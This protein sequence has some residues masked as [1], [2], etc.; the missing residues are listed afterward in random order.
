[1]R[2]I[3]AFLGFASLGLTTT[4]GFAQTIVR[5]YPGQTLSQLTGEAIAFAGDVDGDGVGDHLVGLRIGAGSGPFPGGMNV[6]S[7]ATGQ[8][9][10]QHVGASFNA[11][12]GSAMGALGDIDQDGFADYAMGSR[13]EGGTGSVTAFSGQTGSQLWKVFGDQPNQSYGQ[14]IEPMADLNGDGFQDLLTAGWDQRVWV[15]SGLDGTRLYDLADTNF[16]FGRT[17]LD[18]GD[19]NGDGVHDFYVAAH[20][21]QLNGISTTG[22]VRIFNGATGQVLL[23]EL[24]GTV[25]NG[26]FGGALALVGDRTG[27]GISEVAVGSVF[28]VPRGAVRIINP[29]NRAVLNT[30]R[31]ED[32]SAS[33][34]IS[35]G[36]AIASVGDTNGDGVPDYAVGDYHGLDVD[37]G[38]VFVFSQDD[39]RLLFRYDVTVDARFGYSVAPAGDVDGNGLHKVLVGSPRALGQRGQASVLG[40]TTRGTVTCQ[41][42]PAAPYVTSR[43]WA[44]GDPL[45]S[46]N[47]WVLS[48]DGLPDGTFLYFIA[49]RTAGSIANPGGSPSNL[50]LGG[51]IARLKA[52]AGIAQAGGYGAPVDLTRIPEP[53]GLQST[54]LSGETWFFQGWFRDQSAGIPTTNF[55]SALEFT[56]Q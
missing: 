37:W 29:M 47:Q 25:G 14:V 43:I 44:T 32:Y 55:T 20:L 31:G 40:V 54:I 13:A 15:L 52:T 7:G 50:C 53:P 36:R 34:T 45:A 18:A 23:P 28:E 49:S 22:F 9:I 30:L 12:A 16:G 19:L 24:L 33:N 39:D 6:F 27:D 42:Q 56:F 46:S 5:D 3:T 17:M 1:M 2:L 35:F 48:A 21:A 26:A 38:S 51:N 41:N 8:F 10:R 4:Q 11:S